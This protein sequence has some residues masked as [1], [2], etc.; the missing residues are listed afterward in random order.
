L[1]ASLFALVAAVLGEASFVLPSVLPP[2]SLPALTSAAFLGAPEPTSSPAPT[3][4]S[5]PTRVW[6]VRPTISASNNTT[7]ATASLLVV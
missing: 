1:P 4:C 5:A 3:P 7:K 6:Q 2:V